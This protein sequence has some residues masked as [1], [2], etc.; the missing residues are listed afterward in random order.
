MKLLVVLAL[1][2]VAGAAMVNVALNGTA[3]QSSSGWGGVAGRAIDGNDA[4]RYNQ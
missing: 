1:V 2:G 4:A 3:L